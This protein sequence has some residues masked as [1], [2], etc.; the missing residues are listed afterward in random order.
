MNSWVTSA[1]FSANSSLK[2]GSNAFEIL[3]LKD[4][5]SSFESFSPSNLFRRLQ[6]SD[7]RKDN[8]HVP[9][10]PRVLILPFLADEVVFLHRVECWNSDC[11]L[12]WKRIPSFRREAPHGWYFPPFHLNNSYNIQ[13]QH[14][15][16]TL[17]LLLILETRGVE[18]TPL[19]FDKTPLE[20]QRSA[21]LLLNDLLVLT[22]STNMR[23]NCSNG[24][25]PVHC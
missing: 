18:R 5:Y 6:N 14:Q 24:Q 19:S 1:I 17:F 13:R 25:L 2:L 12:I 22:S 4:I 16:I 15:I 10:S 3:R 9:F 23:N 11:D 8:P 20:D 21:L 7:I